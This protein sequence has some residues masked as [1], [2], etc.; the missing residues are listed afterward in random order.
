MAMF[1][2]FKRNKPKTFG[3]KTNKEKTADVENFYKNTEKGKEFQKFLLLL[4]A[5]PEQVKKVNDYFSKIGFTIEIDKQL[6]SLE[7][8]I[9]KGIGHRV[10]YSFDFNEMSEHV[11]NDLLDFYLADTIISKSE[12]VDLYDVTFG[13]KF[14]KI[15]LQIIKELISDEV[16]AKKDDIIRDFLEK[17]FLKHKICEKL[18]NTC[19]TMED[20][21]KVHDEKFVEVGKK[22]FEFEYGN[23]VIKRVFANGLRSDFLKTSDYK[24]SGFTVTKIGN[25]PHS[26]DVMDMLSKDLLKNLLEEVS[27][28]DKD[29]KQIYLLKEKKLKEHFVDILKPM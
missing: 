13:D 17:K 3:E 5:D 27:V 16:W 23:L 28:M 21:Q 24:G 12:I 14:D 22:R 8:V 19:K 29:L 1:N 20:I 11:T 2:I 25:S 7:T 10:K 15:D 4:L 18:K 6:L 26:H 9:M